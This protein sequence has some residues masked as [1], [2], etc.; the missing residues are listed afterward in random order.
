MGTL[1]AASNMVPM[2][3]RIL[4]EVIVV[5]LLGIFAYT[6]FF[7]PKPDAKDTI[8]QA[9]LNETQ[10]TRLNELI[11]KSKTTR[12]KVKT[13][14]RDTGKDFTP[15]ATSVQREPEPIQ[16][17]VE[18]TLTGRILDDTGQLILAPVTVYSTTCH[19]TGIS[20][21]G[22]FRIVVQPGL[23]VVSAQRTIG[24]HILEAQP[25]E[26]MI[27]EGEANPL[28][29][30]MPAELMGTVGIDLVLHETYAEVTAVAPG[31]PAA[32][33]GLESGHLIFE[34]NGQKVASL[35]Q[36]DIAASLSGPVDEEVQMLIVVETA[37]GTL[38][39]IPVALGRIVLP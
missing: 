34:I 31:S 4:I 2:K 23:C 22:N 29:I 19:F 9:P 20:S 5:L 26:V 16:E 28:T 11:K 3:A 15:E 37:D 32:Q 25:M 27:N 24:E 39:E 6:K 1:Y 7:K 10:S 18:T 8:A 17:I 36:D 14:L 13:P 12:A 35:S 30:I 38:R 33:I 21:N